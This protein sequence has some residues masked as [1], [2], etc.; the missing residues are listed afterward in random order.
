MYYIDL[1]LV[2]LHKYYSY[3][4]HLFFTMLTYY[5]LKYSQKCSW[6]GTADEQ[7]NGYINNH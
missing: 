4:L 7:F 2:T 3:V 6:A 1:A 5:M